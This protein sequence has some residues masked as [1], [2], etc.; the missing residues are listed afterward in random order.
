MTRVLG[1][2]LICF[3]LVQ[4][5]KDKIEFLPYGS[6]TDA[7]ASLLSQAIDPLHVTEIPLQNPTNPNYTETS[8]IGSRI[9]LNNI[10]Q[11]FQD[12]QSQDVNCATC[13]QLKIKITEALT[14]SQMIAHGLTSQINANSSGA[15]KLEVSCDG[16]P[17]RLK[18][19]ASIQ[20]EVPSQQ[21]IDGML[22]YNGNLDAAGKLTDWINTNDTLYRYVQAGQGYQFKISQLGWVVGFYPITGNTQT[23]CLD[24]DKKYNEENTLAYLVIDGYQATVKLSF[25]RLTDRFCITDVPKN[26]TGK[27]VLVAKV[28]DQWESETLSINTSNASFTIVPATKTDQEIVQAIKAL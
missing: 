5:R 9:M 26:Q 28:G 15:V 13:A 19:G 1:L 11:L 4:C 23:I 14:N 16:R 21:N 12:D 3:T 25:D 20:V 24:L 6:Q 7:I 17:L 27:L 18:P 22:I 10:N 8:Q 2:V